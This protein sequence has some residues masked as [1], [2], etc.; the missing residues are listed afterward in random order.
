MRDMGFGLIL[1]H[2]SRDPGTVAILLE[3]DHLRDPRR[4]FSAARAAARL[5]PVVAIAPGIRLSDPQGSAQAALEAAFARAGV[6]LTGTIGEFLAAAETL[7]HVK[8]ARGE[9]LA[10]LSNSVSAGRLAADCALNSGLALT[11]LNPHTAQV[12]AL[13]LGHTPPPGPIYAGTTPT[14][15]AEL[16]ALLSSAPEVGGILI[17]HAPS[18]EDDSAA[19]EALVACAHTVKIPLLIAAMGEAHGG[20]HRRRLTKAGLACFVTPERAIAGFSHLLRNRR[21][22]AAARELPPSAVLE[23]APD[24]AAV[25]TSIAA[26][27]AAGHTALVQ[28]DALALI[29]A[30]GIPVIASRRAATP[31]NAVAAAALL[32]FP[33][34]S[35]SP[36]PVR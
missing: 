8:P 9:S 29:A 15:L 25:A 3:I 12:L 31:E 28:D 33:P 1:D 17:V 11:E 34:C 27:R 13:S 30:Y 7:T 36:I 10:I 19:I 4:F 20:L 32:G 23:V 2:L 6:L 14:R 18:G 22:R 16:A 5:R 35:N 26:A 24:K 21:N